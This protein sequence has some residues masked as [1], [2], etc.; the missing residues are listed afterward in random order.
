MPKYEYSTEEHFTGKYWIDGKKIYRKVVTGTTS[1]VIDTFYVITTFANVKDIIQ[2]KLYCRDAANS[3]IE[4][5][6]TGNIKYFIDEQNCLLLLHGDWHSGCE[7]TF[8]IEY[9]KLE[10]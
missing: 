4:V 8:I 10:D 1:T 6:N 5:S 9:T 2:M 7:F 3:L